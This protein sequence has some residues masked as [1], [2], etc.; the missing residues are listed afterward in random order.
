MLV[1]KFGSSKSLLSLSV[2]VAEVVGISGIRV[3]E[4]LVASFLP[5]ENFLVATYWKG[6]HSHSD[7]TERQTKVVKI[8]CILRGLDPWTRE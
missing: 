6:M 8:W 7:A 3:C 5:Q 1:S 2:K 4:L